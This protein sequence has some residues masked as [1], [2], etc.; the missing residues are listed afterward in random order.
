MGLGGRGSGKKGP[1]LG[2]KLARGEQ[3]SIRKPRGNESER[4][5]EGMRDQRSYVRNLSSCETKLEK[6][7]RRT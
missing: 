6:K 4:G 1:F 7:I 2:N 3:V 5:K